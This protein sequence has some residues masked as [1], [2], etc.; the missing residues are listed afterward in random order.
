MVLIN[1]LTVDEINA[2]LIA[3]Q[4][5]RTQII[6]TQQ[7]QS[8]EDP[9]SEQIQQLESDVASLKESVAS[10]TQ[11]DEYQSVQIRDLQRALSQFEQSGIESLSFSAEDRVLTIQLLSGED[12]YCEIPEGNVTFSFDANTNSL[13]LT[14]GQQTQTVVLP[15]V[16]QSEVGV[17]NG[18]AS[19][20]NTGCIPVSQMPITAMTLRG[21]WDAS[22]N[23]PTLSDSTGN[24]GDFY[25]VKV[26]G[27]VNLGHGDITFYEND[28]VIYAEDNLTPPYVEK[29]TRLSSG[30]VLSV[31]GKTGA[32]ELDA[33]DI[34]VEGDVTVKDEIDNLYGKT[35]SSIFFDTPTR[36]LYIYYTDG[37]AYTTLIP[38][39]TVVTENYIYDPTDSKHRLKVDADGITGQSNFGTEE[40][41]NW[42]DIGK[43]YIDKYGNIILNNSDEQI[44]Y[45][46]KVGGTVYHFENTSH[47]EYDEQGTNVQ[48]IATEGEVVPTV[49]TDPVISSESSPNCFNG[50][51]TKNISSFA[52]KIVFLSKANGIIVGD[53]VLYAD[54][55]T[56]PYLDLSSYN[57][58]MRETSTIDNTKTVGEYLGL[59]AEQIQ[60]GI[61]N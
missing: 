17:P 18:V 8:S 57:D 53:K 37:T 31:N 54:G 61:F 9:S 28:R 30:D 12:L 25:I 19:L 41:P 22:T 6:E 42:Q 21:L 58:A 2:A 47:P 59:N 24:I 13:N 43:V 39:G 7:S 16:K 4:R 10:Q 52:G 15:Y 11:T 23:T 48:S 36:V 32:V 56:E 33:D 45:G 3:L 5:T 60:N 26:G 46:F 27:T 14:V 44:E 34:P 1:N 55:T 51:V 50:K 20:D 49:G 35:I 29:W 40:L 38:E